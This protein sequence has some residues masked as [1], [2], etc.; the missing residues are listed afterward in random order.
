MPEGHRCRKARIGKI[1][2]VRR[3]LRRDAAKLVHRRPARQ[4]H[5]RRS[6][7]RLDR[8]GGAPERP[9]DR[10]GVAVQGER[11]LP[12]ARFA[13]PTART[14]RR[15]AGRPVP[16]VVDRRAVPGEDPPGRLGGVLVAVARDEQMRDREAGSAGE[17]RVDA[18]RGQLVG[19]EGPG[20]VGQ[21]P[22]AVALAV[23]RAGPVGQCDQA[24]AREPGDRGAWTPVLPDDRHQ[25]TGIALFRHRG[26]LRT[27]RSPQQM[28]NRCE[29]APEV[30]VR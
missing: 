21:E 4:A 29:M 8:R 6:G 12:E 7:L 17:I 10:R 30:A 13:G 20:D 24:F 18:A 27:S 5:H 23:D 2:E 22:G 25:G 11:E 16:L 15:S 28:G 26:T 14:E 1:A 3:E 19:P 9:V